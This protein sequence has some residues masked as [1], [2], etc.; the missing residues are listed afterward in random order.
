MTA[1]TG[2]QVETSRTRALAIGLAAIG[3]VGVA[4]GF[5]A[6]ETTVLSSS[7]GPVLLAVGTLALVGGL[8]A[9][10]LIP[11]TPVPRA[12]ARGVYR[13]MAANQD[14]LVA[15]FDLPKRPVYVPTGRDPQSTPGDAV[16]VLYLGGE[17][18]PD[19]V[20]PDKTVLGSRGDGGLALRPSTGPFLGA[21]YR[22]I[23]GGPSDNLELLA[24][25]VADAA[26][27]SFEL[28]AAV[29][30][31]SVDSDEVVFRVRESTFG[32]T[33]SD[34]PVGSLLASGLAVARDRPVRVESTGGESRTEQ[35]VTCRLLAATDQEPTTEQAATAAEDP[36]TDS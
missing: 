25:Q 5:A 11:T 19:S 22:D 3:V 31:D 26:V 4:S 20:D 9:W 8:L 33:G 28:A 15:A 2:G 13:S 30:V 12:T 29:R 36:P 1:E 32:Q 23:P 24:E 35:R 10:A 34:N 6:T 21:L 27:E 17:G 14:A 16:R 7:L 18:V